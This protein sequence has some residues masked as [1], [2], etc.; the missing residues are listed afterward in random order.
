[1][2]D[3]YRA[4][5]DLHVEGR[6]LLGLAIPWDKPTMVRDLPPLPTAPYLEAFVRTSFDES[7]R[8]N[9][10]ARPLFD[11]HGHLRGANPLGVSDFTRSEEGLLFRAL[12]SRIRA[13]DE[14]L[15][16]V[17][18]GAMRAV[19]VGFRPLKHREQRSA[20]GAM[21]RVRTEVMLRELSLAPTGWGQYPEAKV[22]AVRTAEEQPSRTTEALERDNALRRRLGR[23]LIAAR[24][25]T[26]NDIRQA[27][28]TAVK[29][30]FAAEVYPWVKD[31]TDDW[32]VYEVET[33]DP[34]TSGCFKVPYTI[35]QDG[36]VTLGTAEKVKVTY[37]Y[38]AE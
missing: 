18:D 20:Q 12:L 3:L 10:E 15:E 28:D 6:T 32:A 29:A 1:M 25:Q 38:V 34:D 7:L 8:R 9:P 2:T 16:L 5:A 13:A 33:G 21:V 30:G 36:A 35:T 19:S 24:A 17:K 26:F 4:S 14:M 11:T 31:L 23:P 37:E 27:V 22:L